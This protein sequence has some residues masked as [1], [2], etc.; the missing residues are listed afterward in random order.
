MFLFASNWSPTD[1]YRCSTKPAHYRLKTHFTHDTII[2]EVAC[3][4]GVSLHRGPRL[5]LCVNSIDIRRLRS[6]RN[7][8]ADNVAF[9][10][11]VVARIS[12]I[13]RGLY[14]QQCNISIW[15]MPSR[16]RK[17]ESNRWISWCLGSSGILRSVTSQ[18]SERLNYTLAEA[19]NIAGESVFF[20]DGA[21]C[22]DRNSWTRYAKKA[23]E[24]RYP[25]SK[26]I[27]KDRSQ[28]N[29]AHTRSRHNN[30]PARIRVNKAKATWKT[31]AYEDVW[32]VLRVSGLSFFSK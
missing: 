5:N 7:L 20:H 30:T 11:T 24:S 26:L 2:G 19:W 12:D 1:R 23:T 3:I 6:V 25:T 27:T 28:V 10:Y 21:D 16:S 31:L 15:L 8:Q 14:R 17:L 18:K 9:H 4:H 13:L 29:T 22:G 32:I